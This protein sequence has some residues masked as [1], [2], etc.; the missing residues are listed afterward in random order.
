MIFV[1]D[2]DLAMPDDGQLQHVMDVAMI[3]RLR[4]C[5]VV[6]KHFQ[7]MVQREL[8]VAAGHDFQFGEIA[9]L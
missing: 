5:V 2:F 9:A 4:A 3:K 1:G 8:R 6:P 7:R